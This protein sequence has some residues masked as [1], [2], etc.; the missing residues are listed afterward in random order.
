MK[1][2]EYEENPCNNVNFEQINELQMC[3]NANLEANF[4]KKAVH[5]NVLEEHFRK[6][7]DNTTTATSSEQKC[8]NNNPR[9]GK[10]QTLS[11]TAS[12]PLFSSFDSSPISSSST[13]VSSSSIQSN[14]TGATIVT[15]NIA[16]AAAAAPPGNTQSFV[17][18]LN[19]YRSIR[20][21]DKAN[22]ITSN[23]I[24]KSLLKYLL[25][26]KLCLIWICSYI[27]SFLQ[28]I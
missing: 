17:S 22:V 23:T 16:A 2:I 5:V 19:K 14:P 7:S 26:G 9:E 25:E 4:F 27:A 28:A 18:C 8:Q 20:M 24:Y 13:A 11:S 3:E 10:K 12:S 6:N 15:A 21:V 1:N